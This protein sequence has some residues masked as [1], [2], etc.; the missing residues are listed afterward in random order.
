MCRHCGLVIGGLFRSWKDCLFPSLLWPTITCISGFCGQKFIWEYH[1]YLVDEVNTF[2]RLPVWL[3]NLDPVIHIYIY[4]KSI[5]P[6]HPSN[7]HPSSLICCDLSLNP[8]RPSNLIHQS[9]SSNF[10][11]L[12]FQTKPTCIKVMGQFY[13]SKV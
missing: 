8:H 11:H 4:Y 2:R 13:E 6:F 7:F 1:S 5:Y 10:I 9:K 3:G 12:P